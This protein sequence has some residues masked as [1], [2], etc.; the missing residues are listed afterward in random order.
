[1]IAALR[2]ADR[3]LRGELLI[4]P[5]PSAAILFQLTGWIVVCGVGYGTVMG[6]FGGFWGERLFQV[7]ISASKVPILLLGTF[8]I[9]LPSFFVFNTLLGVR[10]DF[11]AVVRALILSQAGLTI[12]LFILAPYT[13][14]WY[15]SFSDYNAAI[16]FNAFVFAVATAGAQVILRR[17]YRPLIERRP[18]HRRL[19]SLWLFLYAFV[20][21][22]MGW[23]LRPFIGDP[24]RPTEFFRQEAWGNAYEIVWRM[25]WRVVWP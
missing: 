15:A 11:D 6:A 10:S 23:V 5:V 8:A 25:V 20:G 12:I 3:L 7:M 22:Q 2:Q 9:C 13:V 16:L 4:R 21:I 14:L 18:I 19:L 17:A 1:M 24:S